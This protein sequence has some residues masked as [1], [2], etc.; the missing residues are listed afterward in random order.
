MITEIGTV[1]ANIGGVTTGIGPLDVLQALRDPHAVLDVGLS[2]AVGT[3]VTRRPPHR[4]QRAL[5][6]H[7][8]PASGPDVKALGRP[9]MLDLGFG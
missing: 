4:S 3:P 7:W 5:L 1:I 9:G 2:V 8:A 6:T